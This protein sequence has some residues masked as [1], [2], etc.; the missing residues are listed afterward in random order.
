MHSF[1]HIAISFRLLYGGFASGNFQVL[2]L[3][4]KK[5]KQKKKTNK[6]KKKKKKK[7]TAYLSDC[8]VV[9]FARYEKWKP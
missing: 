3:Q 2:L 6:Q 8:S 9:V 5:K 4:K 7:N 1:R